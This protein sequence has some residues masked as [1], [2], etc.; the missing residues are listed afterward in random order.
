M[1]NSLILTTGRG[2]PRASTNGLDSNENTGDPGT[3]K[4]NMMRVEAAVAQEVGR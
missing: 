4:P 1:S 3:E 2:K